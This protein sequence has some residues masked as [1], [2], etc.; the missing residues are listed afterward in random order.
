MSYDLSTDTL[1][2]CPNVV[3]GLRIMLLRHL[4]TAYFTSK[5]ILLTKKK[6]TKKVRSKVNFPQCLVLDYVCLCV[7]SPQPTPFEL[8]T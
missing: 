3:K 8:G 4:E 6:I 1:L 7:S 2:T 5:P